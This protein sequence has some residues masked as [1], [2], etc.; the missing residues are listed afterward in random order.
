MGGVPTVRVVDARVLRRAAEV[1]EHRAR[2]VLDLGR[3][4]TVDAAIRVDLASATHARVAAV[5]PAARADVTRWTVPVRETC[6]V[7][8]ATVPSGQRANA[9]RVVS[10]GAV[11]DAIAPVRN[12]DAPPL[13]RERARRGSVR[14]QHHGRARCRCRSVHRRHPTR[15]APGTIDSGTAGTTRAG[16]D[17]TRDPG[18]AAT[19]RRARGP[20]RRRRAR[21]AGPGWVIQRRSTARERA[22]GA[23]DRQ[24]ETDRAA[25]G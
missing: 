17:R 15:G 18:R 16:P 10:S 11:G 24:P 8:T 22:H 7:R 23:D 3:A 25:H 19:S 9:A 4:E 2:A 1:A 21:R 12:S 14:R 13:T 5:D 20:G 6:V